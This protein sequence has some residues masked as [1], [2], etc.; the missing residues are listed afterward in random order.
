MKPVLE[1]SSKVLFYIFCVVI[2]VWTGSLTVS[3]VTRVMPGAGVEPF[4]ALAVFDG[5]AICWLLVFLSYS[6]GLGQRSVSLLMMVMDL[7]GIGLMTVAELLMGGQT[8]TDAP[9][10]LGSVAV[11]AIALWTI[12][13][14]IA[15]YSF[16]VLSPSAMKEIAMGVAKDKVEAQGIKYLEDNLS[17]LGEQLGTEMGK[18]LLDQAIRD[19]GLHKDG[20]L[21]GGSIPLPPSNS[22][23]SSTVNTSALFSPQTYPI[24]HNR[25]SDESPEEI[26]AKIRN[27]SSPLRSD[28]MSDKAREEAEEALSNRIKT[29]VTHDDQ[30]RK[31]GKLHATYNEDVIEADMVNVTLQNDPRALQS[32]EQETPR[33]N[34][35][36]PLPRK[37]LDSRQLG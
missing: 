34:G 30:S 6:K 2:V 23:S 31:N 29:P 26:M 33:P 1:F 24:T 3:F 5:G 22:S 4:L 15:A 12:A 36:K 9:E 7:I 35:L 13:N 11:W 16:H 27:G 37:K 8:F 20:G 25:S 17:K 28:K 32:G 21:R 14:V 18:A 10:Q 19:M